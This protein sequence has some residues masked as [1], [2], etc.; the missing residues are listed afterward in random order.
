LIDTFIAQ[1]LQVFPEICGLS[2]AWA[3]AEDDK[4]KGMFTGEW[5]SYERTSVGQLWMQMGF[6]WA[7]DY[8]HGAIPVLT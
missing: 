4:L 1:R 8:I 2:R 7:V 5:F 3:A 6:S